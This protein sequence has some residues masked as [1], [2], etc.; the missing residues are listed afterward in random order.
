MKAAHAGNIEVAKLLLEYKA[1]KNFR[2]NKNQTAN[3]IAQE[4][5]HT[6]IVKLLS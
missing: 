3:D 4:K 1:D 5:G 6:E 2:N